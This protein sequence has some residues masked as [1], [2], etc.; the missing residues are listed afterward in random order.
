MSC[1]YCEGLCY[2]AYRSEHLSLKGNFYPGIDVSIE[3]NELCIDGCADTYEPNYI[4][5][6]IRI[7]FCPICG[8][9]L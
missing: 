4:E 9:K 2:L 1:D 3:G 8:M 5:E 7:N 6:S